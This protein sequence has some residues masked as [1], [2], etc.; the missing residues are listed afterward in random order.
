M[1]T[2]WKQS[3]YLSSTKGRDLKK[4]DGTYPIKLRVWAGHLGKTGMYNTGFYANSKDF[5][6]SMSINPRG[7][8]LEL[9][10][11]L[12]LQ[13]KLKEIERK[14]DD[15]FKDTSVF[16]MAQFKA[17]LRPK[18]KKEVSLIVWDFMENQMLPGYTK[19]STRVSIGEGIKYIKGFKKNLTFL[20]FN[21]KTLEKFRI[22]MIDKGLSPSTANIY[23]RYLRRAF[24]DGFF[25]IS[26]VKTKKDSLTN[27]EME[28]LK[29]YKPEIHKRAPFNTLQKTI[30]LFLFSYYCGGANYI[31]IMQLTWEDFS[32]DGTAFTFRRTKTKDTQNENIT[33]QLTDPI[34][35]IIKIW[36]VEKSKFVFGLMNTKTN[37]FNRNTKQATKLNTRLRVVAKELNFRPVVQ[38]KLSMVWA[39]HSFA[40]ITDRKNYSLKQI[41]SLM[42]HSNTTTTENYIGS[43]K[44]EES[45]KMQNDL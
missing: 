36:G 11:N 23:L 17:S 25:S 31:D 4:D 21:V 13:T 22:Y 41:G 26:V 12:E 38:E 9:K 1:R 40:T 34:K 33:I 10:E 43:L 44:K 30:D 37:V 6:S 7:K 15:I 24:N 3:F 42:G 8:N 45:L 5:E 19:K 18:P 29:H 14:V 27:E 39:R 28:M 20:D 2:N 16:T 32:K 35:A